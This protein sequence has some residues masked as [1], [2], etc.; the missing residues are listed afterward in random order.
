MLSLMQSF[1]LLLF[2]GFFLANTRNST[3]LLNRLV[4]VLLLPE[5]S[6]IHMC[7]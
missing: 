3:T 6:T 2:W 4:S 1:V 7:H 5:G